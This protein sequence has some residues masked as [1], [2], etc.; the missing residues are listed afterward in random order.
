MKDKWDLVFYFIMGF[1]ACSLIWL[2]FIFT[3]ALAGEEWI[4]SPKDAKEWKEYNK[5]KDSLFS[6][7][8]NDGIPNRYDS[9][10]NDKWKNKKFR[11]Y[12]NDGQPNI[13]DPYDNKKWVPK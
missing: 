2:V 9:F 7:Y 3:S 1:V 11:D 5:R 12:D 6:D 13:V 10:D 4:T 8:D